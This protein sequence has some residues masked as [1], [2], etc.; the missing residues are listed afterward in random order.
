ML[1]IFIK[2]QII[3]R[4]FVLSIILNGRFTQVLLYCCCVY[5]VVASIAC[6]VFVLVPCFVVWFLVSFLVILL[7]KGELVELL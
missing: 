7:S 1:S 6:G 3:I 4:I 2:L 5:I